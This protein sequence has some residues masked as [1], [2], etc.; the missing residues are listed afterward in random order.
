MQL[1]P[2]MSE[3]PEAKVEWKKPTFNVGRGMYLKHI[4]DTTT[5]V[6]VKKGWEPHKMKDIRSFGPFA[7]F[8]L[9]KVEDEQVRLALKKSSPNSTKARN[10][11][12][13]RGLELHEILTSRSLYLD[14]PSTDPD[15]LSMD[16]FERNHAAF[17]IN[18]DLVHFNHSQSAAWAI[19]EI[20]SH[21]QFYN[22]VLSRVLDYVTRGCKETRE[23]KYP[24]FVKVKEIMQDEGSDM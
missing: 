21:G 18:L 22:M 6:E 9:L 13:N 23:N 16:A 20:K 12:D 17:L 5:E 11:T 4:I 8:R 14:L 3:L 10:G 2:R 15:R 1:T 24:N 19:R 7:T